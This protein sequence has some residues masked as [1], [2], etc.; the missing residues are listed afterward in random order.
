MGILHAVS[1][2]PLS[3]IGVI[4]DFGTFS[5]SSSISEFPSPL[6]DWGYPSKYISISGPEQDEG[7][8]PLSGIGVIPVDDYND[9]VEYISIVS[10]PS[11]GLGLSQLDIRAYGLIPD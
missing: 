8:R 11:R 1:F 3:G 6:G 5:S 10:V 2:R 7:F 9:K 4:P